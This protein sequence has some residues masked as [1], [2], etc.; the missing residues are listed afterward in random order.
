MQESVNRS[1]H[2]LQ[3]DEDEDTNGSVIVVRAYYADEEEPINSYRLTRERA[4]EL[5]TDIYE[6]IHSE[7]DNTQE[8]WRADGCNVRDENGFCVAQ[9]SSTDDARITVVSMKESP[10][11]PEHELRA[12]DDDETDDSVILVCAY[13]ADHE[14][15]IGTYRLTPERAVTLMID[16]YKAIPS[17]VDDPQQAWNAEGCNVRDENGLTV[18]H[19]SS[20]DDARI[21]AAA[22][23][24]APNP[25]CA[26]R[27]GRLAGND[28]QSTATE[29]E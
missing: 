8:P 19:T 16:L 23:A 20:A 27:D 26:S 5:M 22:P 11:L 24:R 10:H 15:P 18:A 14:E 25:K 7:V 21:I 9:T 13:I 12:T 4:T 17:E 28:L 6:A 29:R 2:V 3:A 1:D